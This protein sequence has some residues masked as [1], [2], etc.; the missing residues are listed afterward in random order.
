MKKGERERE[1]EGETIGNTFVNNRT[2]NDAGLLLPRAYY[3]YG[4]VYVQDGLRSMQ[5][6]GEG[7]PIS[8]GTLVLRATLLVSVVSG[9]SGCA[10]L[11]MPICS[12]AGV[13]P[14]MQIYFISIIHLRA[15]YK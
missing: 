8:Y 1:R 11:H 12:A 13:T 3:I 7:R 15:A 2:Q 14:A 5:S 6:G 4:N 9:S 10:A